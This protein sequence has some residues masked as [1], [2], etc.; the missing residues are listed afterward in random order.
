M[1]DSAANEFL[2]VGTT[3]DG[4]TFRPSDWT[5]RLPGVMSQFRPG[6]PRPGSHLGYSP[7]CYPVVRGGVNCVVVH[8]AL[9]DYDVITRQFERI[10]QGLAQIVIVFNNE[11]G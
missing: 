3:L 8:P 6:G 4:R 5:E 11:Y 10:A 9:R 7:W 1:N 2:I